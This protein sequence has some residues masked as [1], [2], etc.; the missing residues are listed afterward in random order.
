MNGGA[1]DRVAAQG[2]CNGDTLVRVHICRKSPRIKDILDNPAH[3]LTVQPHANMGSS[4]TEYVVRTW[5][6][7]DVMM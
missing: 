7:R 3:Y 2:A 6:L 5:T 4:L 1:L